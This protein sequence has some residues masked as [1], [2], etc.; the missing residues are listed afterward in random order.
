VKTLASSPDLERREELHR[1]VA[2]LHERH[3]ANGGI[4]MPRRH[5]LTI[6]RR[7]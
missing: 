1:T 4:R 3:R 7:K 5:L 2:D 6:G